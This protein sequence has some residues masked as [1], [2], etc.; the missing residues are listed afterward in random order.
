MTVNTTPI[1]KE[2]L[3]P[4][5]CPYCKSLEMH[6]RVETGN[7]GA[8]MLNLYECSICFGIHKRERTMKQNNDETFLYMNKA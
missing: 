7:I 1:I 8:Y 6:C 3:V 4:L 2:Y 5:D